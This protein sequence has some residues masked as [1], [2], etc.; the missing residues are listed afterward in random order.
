MNTQY[1]CYL[2]LFS[3]TVPDWLGSMTLSEARDGL[4]ELKMNAEGV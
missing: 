1:Q 4:G 3:Q 2:E